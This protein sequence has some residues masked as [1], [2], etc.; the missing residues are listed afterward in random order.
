MRECAV[1]VN[2]GVVMQDHP[3]VQCKPDVELD[4]VRTVF[5]GEPECFKGVVS[6]MGGSTTVA[7][8]QGAVAAVSTIRRKVAVAATVVTIPVMLIYNTLAHALE[9]FVPGEPDKVSM[10]VCGATVQARPHLGHGRYA[11]VFDVVRNYFEWCGYAVTYVRNITDVED[12]IIAAAEEQG[13]PTDEIVKAASEAFDTAYVALGVRTPDIEPKATEHVPEMIDMIDRLITAGHAYE[14]NGDVYF[15]VR[16]F[17]GY[18]K[19]SGRN[20]D[21]LLSGVCVELERAKR[22]PLDFALWKA[23]KPGEPTWD[24]P[25]GPGRP[26]WHIECSAMAHKYL[27]FSFD[28]HGGGNDLVF[29]HHENEV[30]QAEAAFGDAPFARFWMH[31]GMLTLDLEKMSKSTGH[32]VDLVDAVTKYPGLALR[33][34]YLRTHY[35]KPLDFTVAAIEDAMASLERFWSFR[36]RVP[37]PAQDLPHDGSVTGFREAMDDDFDVA[38]ALGVLFEA[39]REGN[40]RLDDGLTAG[41]WIS[42]YEELAGVLG[43][44]E[45]AVSLEDLAEEIAGLAYDM[46]SPAQEDPVATV[47]ALIERRE[48]ARRDRDWATADAIRDGLGELGI[49][50]ED[51]SDGARWHRR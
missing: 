36:R 25:W 33:L 23:A 14:S 17:K 2:A 41:P 45:P 26:G 28:I 22:D 24:S 15:S 20:I 21:E 35:R 3:A 44:L 39:V 12:K 1:V 9:E 50:L 10:Y 51:T 6:G 8:Y 29:P 7:P 48:E 43:L 11:V 19:L 18:G 40:R 4:S 32:V 34:F 27:G 5:D 46:G 47:D 16:G 37:G 13:V 30:A 49:I 31:N 38:G 42:A